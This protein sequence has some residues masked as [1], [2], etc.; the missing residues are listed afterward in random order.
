MILVIRTMREYFKEYQNIAYST[1]INCKKSNKFPQAILLNGY[2]DTPLL[3]IAKY[4][5][6]SIVCSNEEP[7]EECLECL[8]I[9]NESYTDLIIVDGTS[10]TI[11]KDQIEN[12]QERFSMSALENNGSK[13]YII[14]KIE[15]ATAEAVNSLLKFLEE[16]SSDIYAIIT[17]ANINNVLQTIISRCMNIRLKKASKHQLVV[18]ATKKSIPVEDA[19][20]LSCFL[21]SVD[22]IIDTYENSS[23]LSIKDVTIELLNQMNEDEDLLYF[24]Q[25]EISD[26]IKDKND[27]IMFLELLE[28]AFLDIMNIKSNEE[29]NYQEQREIISS[30]SNKLDKIEDKL[31][32]IMLFKGCAMLNANVKLLLDSLIIK[33]ERS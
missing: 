10:Q 25:I 27:F 20:V 12:I 13:I 14:N 29:I 11:K 32:T 1:L 33:L 3:E 17:T 16:P 18:E 9:E 28:I 23:Y 2:K 24:A 26:V 31:S 5:A 30:L 8:R 21:G 4:V 7:C 15:N 19:L 6:K 22:T